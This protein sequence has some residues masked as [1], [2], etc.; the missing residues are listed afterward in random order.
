MGLGPRVLPVNADGTPGN[1][2]FNM[3]TDAAVHDPAPEFS[4]GPNGNYVVLQSNEKYETDQ[5]T[6]VPVAFTDSRPRHKGYVNPGRYFLRPIHSTWYQSLKETESFRRRWQSFGDLADE[7]MESD[8]VPIEIQSLQ[9][10]PDCSADSREDG[11]D[12]GPASR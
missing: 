11:G 8:P 12:G 2:L 5:E 3:L 7:V 10:I 4:R 9:G 1:P 6:W